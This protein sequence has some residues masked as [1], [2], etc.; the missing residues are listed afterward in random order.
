VTHVRKNRFGLAGMQTRLAEI[1]YRRPWP[2]R[3]DLRLVPVPL[4]ASRT[5]SPFVQPR[6]KGDT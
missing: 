1:V 6:S 2:I 3:L 5:P 4:I